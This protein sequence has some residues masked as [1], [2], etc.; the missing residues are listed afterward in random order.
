[1]LPRQTHHNRQKSSTTTTTM[2]Q[3]LVQ[4]VLETELVASPLVVL[5]PEPEQ[6]PVVQLVL[7]EPQHNPLLEHKS[8]VEFLLVVM[9]LVRQV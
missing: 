1:M 5:Q 2:V 6:E 8:P 9:S 3:L 4:W 7:P